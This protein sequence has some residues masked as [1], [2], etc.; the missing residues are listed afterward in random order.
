MQ[1]FD[2]LTPETFGANIIHDDIFVNEIAMMRLN[3]LTVRVTWKQ[4]DPLMVCVRHGATD[5]ST[6]DV[7]GVDAAGI[8]ETEKGAFLDRRSS[9]DK[10]NM[11]YWYQK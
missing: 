1:R 2:D 9:A 10:K 4:I 6:A 5:G 3:R 11:C 7:E 8:V